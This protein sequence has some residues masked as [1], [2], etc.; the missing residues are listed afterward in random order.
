MPLVNRSRTPGCGGRATGGGGGGRLLRAV[1]RRVIQANEY[2]TVS[3]IR[4]ELTL[5]GQGLQLDNQLL[6]LLHLFPQLTVL[7]AGAVGVELALDHVGGD[8]AE[9]G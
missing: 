8:L 9:E 5:V 2:P 3:A 6:Q 4:R 7:K 1:S